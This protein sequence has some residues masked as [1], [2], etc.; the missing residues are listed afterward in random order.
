MGLGGRISDC[1]LV[2]HFNCLIKVGKTIYNLETKE[3]NA[4]NETNGMHATG[5]NRLKSC[6]HRSLRDLY[7]HTEGA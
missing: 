5:L 6:H 1:K 3:D 4:T 7:V 2:M